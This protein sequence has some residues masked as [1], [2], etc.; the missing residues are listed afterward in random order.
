M[1]DT[2]T[3]PQSPP[4]P[5]LPARVPA[6]APAVAQT[7]PPMGMVLIT[8]IQGLARIAEAEG[9]QPKPSAKAW[10]E[11]KRSLGVI[12]D[13]LGVQ[14]AP[15]PRGALRQKLPAAPMQTGTRMQM[16]TPYVPRAHRAAP[17]V[18]RPTGK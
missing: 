11:L 7:A 15:P 14:T 18:P 8:L 3:P 10:G 13:D 16:R 9:S 17:S 12:L 1:A 4:T 2:Q 5:A 6:P